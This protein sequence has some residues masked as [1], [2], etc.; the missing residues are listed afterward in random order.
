MGDK[1][2]K[3]IHPLTDFGFDFTKLFEAAEIA[4]FSPKEREAYEE[5][6]KYYRDI[7]NVVDTSREEGRIEGKIEG[8]LEGKIEGRLEG[9]L[10]GRHEGM[11]EIVQKLKRDGMP[12]SKISQITGLTLDEIAELDL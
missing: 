3:Y 2:S 4:K 12:S 1:G 6:L 10:E 5:S 9:R 8:R 7:K 11:I